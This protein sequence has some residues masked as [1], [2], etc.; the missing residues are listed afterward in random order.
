MA[1]IDR[2][3]EVSTELLVPYNRNAKVHDKS[4]VEKIAESI[5]SFGFLNPCLIDK[6]YNVIAGHGRQLSE[7]EKKIVRS[8]G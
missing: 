2:V 1:K 8:L 6:D 4:Q 7:R 3:Q 5:K